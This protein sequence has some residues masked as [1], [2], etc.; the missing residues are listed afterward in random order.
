MQSSIG[1][2]TSL[3]GLV[4]PRLEALLKQ[5]VW[6]KIE[7]DNQYYRLANYGEIED[8][9]PSWATLGPHNIENPAIVLGGGFQEG[10]EDEN[11]ALVSIQEDHERLLIVKFI[12]RVFISRENGEIPKEVMDRMISAEIK[13]A[14]GGQVTAAL[15]GEVR[16]IATRKWCIQ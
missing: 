1:L 14:K 7:N 8:D 6:F 16:H 5:T 12:C 4:L 13:A 11:G 15:V 10:R 9:G 3:P 2:I